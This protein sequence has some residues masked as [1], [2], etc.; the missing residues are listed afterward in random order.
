MCAG[1]E[2]VKYYIPRAQ[3]EMLKEVKGLE[4]QLLGIKE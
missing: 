2:L 4:L 3:V 1:A